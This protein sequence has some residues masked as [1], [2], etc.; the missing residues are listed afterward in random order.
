MKRSMIDNSELFSFKGAVLGYIQQ[1][2]RIRNTDFVDSVYV[3]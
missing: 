3:V 2:C 1:Y